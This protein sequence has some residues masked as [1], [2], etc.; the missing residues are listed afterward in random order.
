MTINLSRLEDDF[1][2]VFRV[3]QGMD[4]EYVD[5]IRGYHRTAVEPDFTPQAK[6]KFREEAKEAVQELKR[7]YFE[8]AK[9]MIEMIRKEYRPKVE[10]KKY[11]TEE[12]LLNVT[13]WS[14]TIPTTTVDELRQLYLEHKGDPDFEQLLE[15][16]IRRRD[17]TDDLNLQAF[18]HERIAEPQDKAFSE[19]NKLQASLSFLTLQHYYPA[20]LK[21]LKHYELRNVGADLDRYPIDDGH[22]YRPLFDIKIKQVKP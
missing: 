5:L 16:E 11:S 8:W 17:D 9:E 3:Y 6:N 1:Q 21:S 12:R 22:T 15:A 10:P 18:K 13:L 14:Q 20:G 4:E 2:R 7:K 19:L